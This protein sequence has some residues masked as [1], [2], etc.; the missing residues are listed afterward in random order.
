LGCLPQ[1]VENR[2]LGVLYRCRHKGG[3][4]FSGYELRKAAKAECIVNV[5]SDISEL[6]AKLKKMTGSK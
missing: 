1:I 6:T 4:D 3:I 2:P 5:R